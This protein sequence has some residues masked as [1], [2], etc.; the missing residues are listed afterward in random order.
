MQVKELIKR[1][2]NVVA[3][4]CEQSGIEGKMTK[5]DVIKVAASQGSMYCYREQNFCYKIQTKCPP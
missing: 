2:Y 1:G 3:F 5:E 4:A